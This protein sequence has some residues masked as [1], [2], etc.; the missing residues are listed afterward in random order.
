MK[1]I[2]AAWKWLNTIDTVCGETPIVS[3]MTG[4][5]AIIGAMSLCY[6]LMLF[7]FWSGQ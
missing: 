1:K 5:A 3:F 2:K 4:I 6:V 7:A